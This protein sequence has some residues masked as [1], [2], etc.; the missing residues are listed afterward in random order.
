MKCLDCGIS[1]PEQPEDASYTELLCDRC[2]RYT[3]PVYQHEGGYMV[4]RPRWIV[5][6]A[7]RYGDLI[8]PSA[9][10]HDALMNKLIAR[11]GGSHKLLD[12]D[13][14]TEQG[15]IDQ[16]GKWWNRED[17]FIIAER[18]GQDVDLTRNSVPDRLYSEGLY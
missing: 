14:H 10:H 8:V 15:F 17:A 6:A 18:N 9:R 11:L 12:E 13:G 1:I 4:C 16:Y 5:C 7:N 3:A 2:E